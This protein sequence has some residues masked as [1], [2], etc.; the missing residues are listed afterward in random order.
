MVQHLD[1]EHHFAS[2]FHAQSIALLGM[3]P[4]EG[5]EK[6]LQGSGGWIAA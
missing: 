2:F 5:T 1:T 6:A 3:N 4:S